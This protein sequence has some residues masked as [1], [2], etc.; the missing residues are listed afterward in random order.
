MTVSIVACG[1]SGENW[2]TIPHDY[3]IGVND[4]FKW[5]HRF[6][7]LLICNHM[8]KFSKE[9]QDIILRTRPVK[10]YT[11]C[12][13]WEPYFKD[14]SWIKLRSWDGILRK[15]CTR[16]THADTS[17]IIAMSLAFCMGAKKI[18]LHGCDMVTHHIYSKDNPHTR[19]E[20]RKYRGFIEAMKE[21]GT[22]TFISG[23][24]ALDE[25][26]PIYG[27]QGN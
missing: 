22:E 1:A 25:F 24:G 12:V 5:G 2:N 7:A 20:V 10:L 3:S 14:I 27:M 21:V 11:H 13:S 8:A 23:P 18:I 9:R 15:D 16:L 19:E 17:P 6:N 4:A 26:V